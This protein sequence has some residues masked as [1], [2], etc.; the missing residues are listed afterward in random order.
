MSLPFEIKVIL[1][2][3]GIELPTDRNL[4]ESLQRSK[5]SLGIM[6]ILHVSLCRSS[7]ISLMI[8][9]CITSIMSERI[10]NM[11]I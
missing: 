5:S 4:E 7:W 3:N 1:L 11:K 9:R 6:R 10:P 8:S 2:T